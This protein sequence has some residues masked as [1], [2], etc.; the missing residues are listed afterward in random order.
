MS[1][2]VE[3]HEQEDKWFKQHE[4]DLIETAKEK[5][6][7]AEE[8]KQKELHFMHCPKCGHELHHINIEGIVLDKCDKCEGLWFDKGELEE[9]QKRE[10]EHKHKF[11]GKF[12]E[13]FK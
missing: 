9:L 13:M 7:I 8:E 1:S 2:E 4:E 3:K 10:H 5:K 12:I 11:F 6:R